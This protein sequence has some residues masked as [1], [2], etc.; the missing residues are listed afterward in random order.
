MEQLSVVR[1][2]INFPKYDGYE[3][4]ESSYTE[5]YCSNFLLKDISLFVPNTMV[6]RMKYLTQ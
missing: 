5:I 1:Y 4:D 3:K 2:F 6:K